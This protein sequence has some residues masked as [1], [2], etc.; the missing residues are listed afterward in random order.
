MN[1]LAIC[2]LLSRQHHI[3]RCCSDPLNSPQLVLSRVSS[4]DR[5]TGFARAEPVAQVSTAGAAT[6]TLPAAIDELCVSHCGS[7]IDQDV[8]A[9]WRHVTTVK[10]EAEPF[11]ERPAALVVRVDDRR[12]AAQCEVAERVP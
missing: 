1:A 7:L 10:G 4:G 5:D 9:G 11:G 3:R 8:H 2:H 6:G 12:E